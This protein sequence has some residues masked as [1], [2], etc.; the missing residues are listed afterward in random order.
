MSQNKKL[1]TIF[2]IFILL[3]NIILLPA[4]FTGTFFGIDLNIGPVFI[5]VVYIVSIAACLYMLS[6]SLRKQVNSTYWTLLSIVSIVIAVF[7][8]SAVNSLSNF[9]F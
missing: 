6:F 5:Y 8:I 3:P 9:G 2:V 1:T 4:V 7:V